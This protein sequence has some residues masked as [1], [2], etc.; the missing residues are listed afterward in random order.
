MKH[1]DINTLLK[2]T[3]ALI[4]IAGIISQILS[5]AGPVGP[6][7]S[8]GDPGVSVN[9]ITVVQ[10]CPGVTPT[11]PLTF[12]EIGLCINNSLYAVYSANDGFLTQVP[13]G[14]YRSNAI[15]SACN[16]TVL[17]NCVIQ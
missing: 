7:G 9:Q 1:N 14:Q 3:T 8:K 11:Y 16:F 2:V 5:C 6:T 15:G 4:I 10:F 13:P 12:P 17:S